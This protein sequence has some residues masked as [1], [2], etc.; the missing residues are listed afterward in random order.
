MASEMPHTSL[1]LLLLEN[2]VAGN[3]TSAVARSGRR[4]LRRHRKKLE[5]GRAIRRDRN[6]EQAEALYERLY[7]EEEDRQRVGWLTEFSSI[8]FKANGPAIHG[9]VVRQMLMMRE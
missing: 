3:E 6:E 7:H 9:V 4:R 5:P 2:T 8:P 1:Q